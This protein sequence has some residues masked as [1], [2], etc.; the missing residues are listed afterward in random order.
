M[1]NRLLYIAEFERAGFS[2]NNP[3]TRSYLRCLRTYARTCVNET[4]FVHIIVP[5][6]NNDNIK[7]SVNNVTYVFTYICSVRQG[8]LLNSNPAVVC[9]ISI[10]I[11]I[12][13]V[14]SMQ[15]THAHMWKPICITH[16]F[17]PFCTLQLYRRNTEYPASL[18]YVY[19]FNIPVY[20]R[21]QSKRTFIHLY[22]VLVKIRKTWKE[23]KR[24]CPI[25]ESLLI[26]DRRDILI[27]FSACLIFMS[28]NKMEQRCQ[29]N[30]IFSIL[31]KGNF[32]S[33][34]S[35]AKTKHFHYLVLI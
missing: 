13:D 4:G 30:Q 25:R 31:R 29:R 2:V 17:D 21:N 10:I 35:T 15:H 19:N 18:T 33:D 14:N 16:T 6:I 32:F 1:I 20:S 9:S 28:S 8:V 7:E 5:C 27:R 22:T 26:M 12:S 23:S 24:K 3:G 34:K 11:S